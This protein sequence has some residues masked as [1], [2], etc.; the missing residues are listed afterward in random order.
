MNYLRNRHGIPMNFANCCNRGPSTLLLFFFI[1]LRLFLP[2]SPLE[3]HDA[4][5]ILNATICDIASNPEKFDGKLVRLNARVNLGLEVFLVTDS[6]SRCKNGFWLSYPDQAETILPE[7]RIK[8]IPVE[9]RKDEQLQRF[10]KYLDAKMY[11][12]FE[13]SNCFCKRYEVLATLTGRVDVATKVQRGFGHLNG[14]KVQFVLQ[15]VADIKPIDLSTNFDPNEY[16][17]EPVEPKSKRWRTP[18]STLK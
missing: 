14:W 13:E 4:G 9:L 3:A 8:R 16:T 7:P 18:T 1:S 15:S 2:A 12:R 10:E 6:G 11:P 17:T 5:K